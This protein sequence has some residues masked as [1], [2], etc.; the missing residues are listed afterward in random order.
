MVAEGIG[1][2]LGFPWLKQVLGGGALERGWLASAQAIGGLLGGVLLGRIMRMV[3]APQLIGASGMM[4]GLLSLAMFNV[5][6]FPIAPALWLPA[7]LSLKLLMGVPIMGLFVSVD[8]MLQQSVGDRYRGRVFGAYGAVTALAV[9]SGQVLASALG[10]VVGIVALLD[11]VGVI[12][13]LAGVL[14]LL[15]LGAATSAPASDAARSAA[16]A[17]V[18]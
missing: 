12:Y 16:A 6:S 4:L 8:T 11:G 5:P 13:F 3:R 10:D 7:V 1:N 9:L 18:A 17:D 2:V 15:L 14:G